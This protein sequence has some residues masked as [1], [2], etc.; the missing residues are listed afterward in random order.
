MSTVRFAGRGERRLTRSRV[1]VATIVGL[2]LL[3]LVA[4][5]LLLPRNS[6]DPLDPDSTAP[7]G[8]RALA[9]VLRSE[10]VRVQVVRTPAEFVAADTDGA[11][12][13]LTRPELLARSTL[14]LTMRHAA[15]ARRMAVITP[16]NEVLTGL[17]LPVHATDDPGSTSECAV[18]WLR[19][20]RLS[21]ADLAY[22]VTS[23]RAQT[24]AGNSTQGAVLVLPAVAGARPQ[25]VLLGSTAAVT[26]NA[27]TDA[28]NAA[29]AMRTLGTS[30]KLIW[31]APN[32]ATGD[33]DSAAGPAW[34]AWLGPGTWLAAAVAVLAIVWRGRRFGRLAREP[35]PVVVPADETTRSRASLYRRAGDT[36]RSSRVLRTAARGRLTRYLGLPAS[37]APATLVDEVARAGDTDPA[38]VQQLLFGQD[39]TN[40][41]AMTDTARALQTLERQV[42]R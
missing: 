26:N 17:G 11:T 21:R 36:A 20:L 35:L 23:G 33:S 30:P 15:E 37:V 1:V 31:F 4:L 2:L 14:E 19:G 8:T 39:D 32:L 22:R 29:I 28:D 27:V 16:D 13:V 41:E 3:V 9:Q 25:T 34:P 42:R 5:T 24:C 6:T 10:G 12:V 7:G 18:G 40:E 38:A